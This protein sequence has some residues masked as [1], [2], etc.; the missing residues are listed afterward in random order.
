MQTHLEQ[1]QCLLKKGIV[2]LPLR[3]DG[4]HLDIARMG[5]EPVHLKTM[6][7]DLK[8]LAFNSITFHFA[9]KPPDHATIS[10]WFSG[11][12]GNIGILGG[13]G[14]LVI[15]DFDSTA[16]YDA[17]CRRHRAVA[18]AAPRAMTPGGCHVFL[19]LPMPLKS[20]SMHLGLRRAGHIKALGGYVVS[21][22]SVVQ[23]EAYTWLP[24]RSLLEVEPPMVADLASVSLRPVSPIKQGYDRLM[25]RGS[26]E[27]Q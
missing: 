26:F 17:W 5:Y 8:E 23:G 10:N 18:D 27:L 6:R 3:A 12:Q 14:D 25:R 9:Q 21:S 22:P 2:C 13:A 4:K 15:L 19:R 11:H 16:D 7:K 1:A 24:G 20:S